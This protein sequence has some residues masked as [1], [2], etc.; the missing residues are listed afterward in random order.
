[1]SNPKNGVTVE[2]DLRG[3][4]IGQAH[5][6]YRGSVP[7]PPGMDHFE[8]ECEVYEADGVLS[9]HTVCPKCR[10]GSWINGKN[11]KIEYDKRTGKLFVE[12]F[13]CGWEMG[14]E[15]DHRDFGFGLCKLVLAYEGKVA[16]D[17]A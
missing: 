2:H 8:I 3:L 14:G 12:R 17:A 1:M 15:D 13:E 10:H 4:A 5:L 11:K 9:V 16:R 6:I 7:P